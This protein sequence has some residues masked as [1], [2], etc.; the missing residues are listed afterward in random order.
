M[1]DAIVVKATIAGPHRLDMLNA[2]TGVRVGNVNVRPRLAA[3]FTQ[4]DIHASV[5]MFCELMNIMHDPHTFVAQ[6]S[7]ADA[8]AINAK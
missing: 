4:A 7:T 3:N 5:S 1:S 8:G 6:D 2:L